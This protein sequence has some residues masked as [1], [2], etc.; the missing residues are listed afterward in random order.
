MHQSEGLRVRPR[1]VNFLVRGMQMN[2]HVFGQRADDETTLASRLF[3]QALFLC[4]SE[5]KVPD[6]NEVGRIRTWITVATLA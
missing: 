4:E 1:D 6:Q 3:N 5:Q 2:G